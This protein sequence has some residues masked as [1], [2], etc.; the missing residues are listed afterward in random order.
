[1]PPNPRA[2]GGESWRFSQQGG[3][4]S[5]CFTFFGSKGPWFSKAQEFQG[6]LWNAVSSP[7]AY[8]SR[9]NSAQI[10]N[11]GGA[12][13]GVNDLVCVNVHRQQYRTLNQPKASKL[14]YYLFSLL[15]METT[16][17]ERV[18]LM[19]SELELDQPGFGKIAGA[20]K[21]VVNQWLSA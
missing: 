15:N 7:L 6:R 1:M 14:D 3:I 16:T 2:Q 4:G 9:R 21:S 18:A 11:L 17:S 8:R 19:M 13:D 5:C 12:S 20:S 10:S